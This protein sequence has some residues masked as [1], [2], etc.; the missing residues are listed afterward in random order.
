[1]RILL[2]SIIT[3]I[4]SATLSQAAPID[5]DLNPKSSKVGFTYFFDSQ[6]VNGVLPITGAELTLDFVNVGQSKI[7]VDLNAAGVKAGLPFAT[8]AL[9]GPKMLDAR[10]NPVVRFVSSRIKGSVNKATVT[11]KLTMAGVTRDVTLDAG[12]FRTAGSTEGDLSK[13]T[14]ILKGSVSR[15]DFGM[16]GFPDPV[17]DEIKINI[18]AVVERR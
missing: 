9:R 13:I 3:I 4:F 18:R 14:V 7:S 11:G 17:E 15:F 8:Q 10:N 16:D 1:M 12:I 2:F 6:G 5:Y